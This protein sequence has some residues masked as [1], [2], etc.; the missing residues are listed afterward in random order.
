MSRNAVVLVC[1]EVEVEY[2][3][4][5]VVDVELS[6]AVTVAAFADDVIYVGEVTVVGNAVEVA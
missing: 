6:V 2:A 5:V 3:E 1:L 4:G